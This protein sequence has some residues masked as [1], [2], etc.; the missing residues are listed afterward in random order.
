MPSQVPAARKALLE[1]AEDAPVG[2]ASEIRHIVQTMMTRDPPA[3]RT[4]VRSVKATP[5]LYEEIRAYARAHPT[6]SLQQ[7]ADHFGINSGRVSEAINYR[8]F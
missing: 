6:A 4:S 1:L 2:L 5:E 8:K 7:I 3:R